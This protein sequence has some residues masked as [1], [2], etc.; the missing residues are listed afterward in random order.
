MYK[1]FYLIYYTMK[2]YHEKSLFHN[3]IDFKN[4]N[5]ISDDII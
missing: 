5:K 4:N 1:I 2:C 3:E